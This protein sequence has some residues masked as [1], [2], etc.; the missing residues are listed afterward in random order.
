MIRKPLPEPEIN[1]LEI[2]LRI[3]AIVVVI[4]LSWLLDIMPP[5]VRIQN[6]K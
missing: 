4:V 5:N 3:L 1:I 6:D 2:W